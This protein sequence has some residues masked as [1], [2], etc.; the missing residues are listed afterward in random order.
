[1]EAQR[2]QQFF[3]FTLQ[4]HSPLVVEVQSDYLFR[5]TDNE[6]LRW[7]VI[8]DGE[9]LAT[10]IVALDIPPQGTQRL[11]LALPQWASAPGEL[12][13]NVEVI[14]PAAT[15]WSAENHL[16]A[17]EQ[18]PLPAPLCIATPK[19]AGTIPQLIHEDDALVIIHQ[20]QRW[21]FDRTSGNLTQW[22]RDGVPTLLS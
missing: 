5:T 13:L 14:Q 19:A 15:P 17:W 8:R 21:Q 12:W 10:D 2:A 22:W 9:V 3:T 11:E 1:Y 4:S 7:S 18:W 20:Q 16:C 6:Q